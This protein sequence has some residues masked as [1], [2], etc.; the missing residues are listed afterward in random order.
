MFDDVLAYIQEDP[1][2]MEKY[3]QAISDDSS[4][5]FNKDNFE[6]LFVFFFLIV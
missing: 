5:I 2:I 1:I 3:A 6:F 4:T